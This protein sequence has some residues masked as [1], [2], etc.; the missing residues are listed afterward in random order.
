MSPQAQPTRLADFRLK[1]LDTFGGELNRPECVLV[2]ADEVVYCSDSRG[3]VMQLHPN[4]TQR[5]VGSTDIKQLTPNGITLSDDGQMLFANMGPD[6]GIWSV[7]TEL[8]PDVPSITPYLM[9]MNGAPIGPINFVLFAPDS[10]LWF[11][12]LSSG[13]HLP[14]SPSRADGFI[15]RL[16]DGAVEVMADELISANE[17]RFDQS[18]GA[19]YVNE[20]FARRT[21]RFDLSTDGTLCNR[22][23]FA[24]YDRGSFP[25][26]MALD[27]EGNLWVTCI[28][29]NQLLVITPRGETHTVYEDNNKQ[30][31]EAV[32]QALLSESLTR[33]LIYSDDGTNLQNPTSIAFGGQDLKTAYV[34]SLT[35]QSLRTFK[36]PVA[37]MP[38]HHWK[39]A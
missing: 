25:D 26:G 18:R 34:G 12:V 14:L 13:H 31:M 35:G 4:G 37:G 33:D 16:K 20:T 22:Q 2:T 17:F 19:L 15:G 11:S 36:A 27:I 9:E 5:W 30:R 21:T 3:G 8:E 29:A 10:S 24:S 6:G 39:F 28:V 7:T 38:M 23:V 32:E 1:E